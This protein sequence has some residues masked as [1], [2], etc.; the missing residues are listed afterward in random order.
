[1]ADILQDHFNAY[2]KVASLFGG[3]KNFQ[4]SA[5]ATLYMEAIEDGATDEMIFLHAT[6]LDARTNE[7]K[8]RPQLAKWLSGRSYMPDNLPPKGTDDASNPSSRLL[9]RSRA[10]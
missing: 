9:S 1:M 5:T 2:W 7:K 3:A 6:R 8:Y 10:E 4:P